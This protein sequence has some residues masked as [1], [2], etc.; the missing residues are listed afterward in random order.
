[1]YCHHYLVTA[2]QGAINNNITTTAYLLISVSAVDYCVPVSVVSLCYCCI[3]FSHNLEGSFRVH[4]AHRF[5]VHVIYDG[6]FRQELVGIVHDNP[7]S[8]VLIVPF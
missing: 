7:S 2:D 5:I 3:C 1:M 8:W 6:N 4:T